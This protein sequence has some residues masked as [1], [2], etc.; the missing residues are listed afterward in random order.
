MV[1]IDFANEFLEVLLIYLDNESD[2]IKRKACVSL[3]HVFQHWSLKYDLFD[4][5]NHSTCLIKKRLDIFLKWINTLSNVLPTDLPSYEQ[6][7]IQYLR[8]QLQNRMES[9]DNAYKWLHEMDKALKTISY[10]EPSNIGIADD[11]LERTVSVR[12]QQVHV[13][14]FSPACTLKSLNKY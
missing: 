3:G 11:D 5:Q 6:K 4:I 12:V 1:D 14:M 10:D 9:T 13:I 2:N 7:L 8:D